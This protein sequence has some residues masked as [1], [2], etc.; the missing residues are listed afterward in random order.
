MPEMLEMPDQGSGNQ[1]HQVTCRGFYC[2]SAAACIII[3]III[4]R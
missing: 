1:Q 3:I 4:I 2:W